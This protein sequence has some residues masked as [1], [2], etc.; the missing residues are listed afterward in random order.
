M[1]VSGKGFMV[2]LF[3][4][5]DIQP[6]PDVLEHCSAFLVNVRDWTYLM[7]MEN[8]NSGHIEVSRVYE[9]DIV[10]YVFN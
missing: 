4:I 7:N 9:F 6:S 5:I 1:S 10:F 8:T 2:S 3:Y